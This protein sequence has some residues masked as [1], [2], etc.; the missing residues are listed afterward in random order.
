LIVNCYRCPHLIQYLEKLFAEDK[1]KSVKAEK[2]KEVTSA[3]KTNPKRKNKN[4]I[5]VK[6][7]MVKKPARRK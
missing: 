5:K 2:V 3:K 6:T 1:S 4:G 7:T